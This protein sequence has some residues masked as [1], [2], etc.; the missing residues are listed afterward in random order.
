MSSGPK[1]SI[2]SG[3]DIF[4]I[5]IIYYNI[6]INEDLEKVRHEQIEL[7]K[8]HKQIE[9]TKRHKQI[10][11]TKRHKQIELTNRHKQI[12]LTKKQMK[13]AKGQV[14]IANIQMEIAKN[15]RQLVLDIIKNSNSIEAKKIEKL[16]QMI[17]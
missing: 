6:Y 10:E 17:Y 9:L 14:E 16:K 5:N 11:L 15:Q 3:E 7:T 4:K 12:E 1:I 13:I 8:R 2:L